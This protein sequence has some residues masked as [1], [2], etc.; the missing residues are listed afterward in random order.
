MEESN[1]PTVV[2]TPFVVGDDGR[3]YISNALIY[4]STIT[5]AQVKT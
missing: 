3:I 4:Q 1:A 5:K 2:G